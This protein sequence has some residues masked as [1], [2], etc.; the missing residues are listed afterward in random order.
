MVFDAK[1]NTN[2][3]GRCPQEPTYQVILKDAHG[4]FLNRRELKDPA[5]F[6][7]ATS[8]IPNYNPEYNYESFAHVRLA[9]L[10]FH[11]F[12]IREQLDRFFPGWEEYLDWSLL[13]ERRSFLFCFLSFNALIALLILRIIFAF[14]ADHH[15]QVPRF[16][17]RHNLRRVLAAFFSA[18]EM[19]WPYVLA[20]VLLPRRVEGLLL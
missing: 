5:I 14:L 9:A 2:T 12:R 4:G 6:R 10:P 7:E 11:E 1:V 17:L 3:C 16:H 15:L 8:L 18:P 13:L 19:K 20:L